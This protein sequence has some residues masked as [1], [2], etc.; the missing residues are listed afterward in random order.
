[1]F[2]EYLKISFIAPVVYE[3]ECISAPSSD[4]LNNPV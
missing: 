2:A 4:N 1:M 3:Q